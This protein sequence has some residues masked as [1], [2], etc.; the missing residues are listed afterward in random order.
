MNQF[1]ISLICKL[2][3]QLLKLIKDAI[4]CYKDLLINELSH[5]SKESKCVLSI[6]N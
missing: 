5:K 3:I 6:R 1:E 2:S 4:Y